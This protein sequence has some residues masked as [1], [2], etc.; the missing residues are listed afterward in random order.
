[1][2]VTHHSLAINF[3]RYGMLRIDMLKNEAGDKDLFY[4]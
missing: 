4:T 2:L 1:M 3:I